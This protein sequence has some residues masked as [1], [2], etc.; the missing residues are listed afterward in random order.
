MLLAVIV[1]N[2]V[3]F[4]L[5]PLMWNSNPQVSICNDTG[6]FIALQ[7][8]QDIWDY[9]TSILPYLLFCKHNAI[10]ECQ[11]FTKD[12]ISSRVGAILRLETAR[13]LCKINRDKYHVFLIN[14]IPRPLHYPDQNPWG[15]FSL[16]SN[17]FPL[18]SSCI[19]LPELRKHMSKAIAVYL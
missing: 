12:L 10:E 17:L 7:W 13:G 11:D 4:C 3:A 19:L 5:N 9:V 8:E 1:D 18:I 6:S 2:C 14:R 16:P 15:S